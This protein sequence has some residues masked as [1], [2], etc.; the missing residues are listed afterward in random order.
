VH[1]DDPDLALSVTSAA[2]HGGLAAALGSAAPAVRGVSPLIG[3]PSSRAVRRMA[4]GYRRWFGA[5][6]P[7]AALYGYEAMRTVLDAIRE[8]GED[9]Q[10]RARVIAAYLG[11][12]HRD[13]V[14]GD[15][16]VTAS[17]D[18]RAPRLGGFR[19]AGG[20]LRLDLRLD[21]G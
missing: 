2:T 10:D 4:A 18:V 15:Y 16:R 19:V 21:A 5:E 9:A 7:P 14:L 11:A 20:A 17:G 1:A 6:P 8:A 13:T 3:I 12:E